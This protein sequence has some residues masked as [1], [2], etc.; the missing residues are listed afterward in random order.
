MRPTEADTCRMYV[1]PKL[2]DADWTDDQISEQRY[3]TA[4]R[5]IVTGRRH[6]R[7]PGKKAD[8]LLSY[9]PDHPIPVVE[10]KAVYKN[11]GDG[12]QQAMEYAE[13]LNLKFAYSTNG[14]GIIE[15]DYTTG[16]QR[17]LD[18]FPSP[19]ELWT[20]F[21]G[22]EGLMDDAAAEDL[23]FPFNRELRNPDGSIKTPRYFQHIA[24]QRTVQA[25]LQGKPRILITMATGTG[26][27]FV[28]VQVAWKLWKTDLKK[29]FET[30]GTNISRKIREDKIRAAVIFGENPSVAPSYLLW[31][32]IRMLLSLQL[33][34][35][36]L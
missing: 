9:R 7:R 28:A 12:L 18:E 25:I 31:L 32:L 29:L 5:I 35:L 24:I 16:R 2:R 22:A 33:F 20:R 36:Q 30:S 17:T 34:L 15:H 27:T 19:A 14:Y 8:Y 23:L 26:K 4:G 10:A 3:F 13:I 6:H 21:R 11:P 1:L